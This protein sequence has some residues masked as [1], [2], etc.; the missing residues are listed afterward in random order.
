MH[1]CG[2]WLLKV[3]PVA[4]LSWKLQ[5]SLA[6]GIFND[7]FS[8]IMQVMKEL[9]ITIGPNCYDFCLEVDSTRIKFSE[10]SLSDEA[11]EVR[12]VSTSSRKDKEREN[13]DL[14][15]QLYGAGIA[16]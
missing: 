4:K 16:D 13:L 1:L 7:G 6:I 15:G 14:E 8:S 5:L 11:K 12:R 10:R 9:G 2:Q 3:F